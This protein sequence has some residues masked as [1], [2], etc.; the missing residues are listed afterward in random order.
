MSNQ[1]RRFNAVAGLNWLLAAW[2]LFKQ[3][4]GVFILMYLFIMVVS[5]IAGV[6]PM[7]AIPITLLITFFTAG[8]YN[9]MLKCQQGQ[10]IDIDELFKPI[11]EKGNRI[12][13][14]RLGIYQILGATLL[15]FLSSFLFTEMQEPFQNLLKAMEVQNIDL[16]AKYQAELIEAFRFS[17]LVLYL[18][19]FAIYS[20]LFAYSI[21][22]VFFKQSQGI[23]DA[24]KQSFR[25]FG[26]NAMPL[27]VFGLVAAVLMVISTF[28]FL[29]PLV[30]LLP[31][32]YIG[33]FISFQDMFQTNLMQPVETETVKSEANNTFDA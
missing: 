33:F 20:M 30:V 12:A 8:Y 17:D 13:L 11:M 16:Q 2:H 25:A 28:L 10:K 5:V 4:P 31:I 14:F 21:P 26:V 27:T 29:L 9:A 7:L 22:L 32:L 6:V 23:L 19:G 15:M 3:N 18:F 1:I 24:L